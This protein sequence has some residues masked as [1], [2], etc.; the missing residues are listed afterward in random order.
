MEKNLQHALLM[1]EA[2]NPRV[3]SERVDGLEQDLRTTTQ[4]LRAMEER[5]E[6]KMEMMFLRMEQ[7]LRDMNMK[8]DAL[9]RGA[10][11]AGDKHDV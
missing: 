6:Q 3:L 2:A 8:I 9:A 7:Q 5:L 11:V 4:D 1:Y 10:L